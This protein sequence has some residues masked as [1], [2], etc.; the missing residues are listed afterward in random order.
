MGHNLW[1][2]NLGSLIFLNIETGKY[3]FNSCLFVCI[4]QVA[5][6]LHMLLPKKLHHTKLARSYHLC[7]QVDHQNHLDRHLGLPSCGLKM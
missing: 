6:V 7:I 4:I 1:S 5:L 3:K 2:L